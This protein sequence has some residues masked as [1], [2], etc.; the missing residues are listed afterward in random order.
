MIIRIIVSNI[1][2]ILSNVQYADINTQQDKMDIAYRTFVLLLLL[3]E[4]KH[5]ECASSDLSMVIDAR[6]V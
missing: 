2:Q 3:R 1:R 6:F 5:T 4:H